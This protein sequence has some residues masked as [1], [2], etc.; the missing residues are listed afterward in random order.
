MTQNTRDAFTIVREA[1]VSA[2]I[3]LSREEYRELLEEVAWEAESRTTALDEEEPI[4]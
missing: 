1:L 3:G 2:S 4:R